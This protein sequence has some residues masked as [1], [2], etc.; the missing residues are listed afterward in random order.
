MAAIYSNRVV[1]LAFAAFSLNST[2]SVAH[3]KPPFVVLFGHKPTLPL[4]LAM[5]ELFNCTV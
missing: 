3:G 1:A 4:D 5:T 2:V